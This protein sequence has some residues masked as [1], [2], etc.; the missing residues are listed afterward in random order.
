MEKEGD[1][2]MAGKETSQNEAQQKI[3]TK[4]DRKVQRRK[5]AEEQEKKQKRFDKLIGFVIVAAIVIA[6]LSIPVSKF[7]ATKS[8]YIKVGGH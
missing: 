2:P 3:V 5:E 7:M 8:T 4:Y 6:L 1:I